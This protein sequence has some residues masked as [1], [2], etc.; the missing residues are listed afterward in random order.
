[1]KKLKLALVLVL[2]ASALISVMAA[3]YVWSF[4]INASVNDMG[5]ITMEDG[6][7]SCVAINSPATA[8]PIQ[9]S[10]VTISLGLL[11]PKKLHTSQLL[12]LQLKWANQLFTIQHFKPDILLRLRLL[13]PIR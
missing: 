2:L 9:T 5:F 7:N 6:A 4:L 11:C 13:L 1:M 12:Q 10:S 8:G 3:A